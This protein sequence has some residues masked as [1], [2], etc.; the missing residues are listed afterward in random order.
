MG[1]GSPGS[2]RTKLFALAIAAATLA[3]PSFARAQEPQPWSNSDDIGARVV[4]AFPTDPGGGRDFP[5]R[6]RGA[7][8]GGWSSNING[9]CYGGGGCNGNGPYAQS[10]IGLNMGGAEGIVAADI[11]GLEGLEGFLS[12]VS[13]ATGFSG[14]SGYF[15]SSNPDQLGSPAY[16]WGDDALG[17]RYRRAFPSGGMAWGV[18]GGAMLLG[19]S[20]A[21]SGGFAGPNTSATGYFA[22]GLFSWR[23]AHG[24]LLSANAGFY[25]DN[26]WQIWKAAASAQ[27]PPV[28]RD[29]SGEERIALGHT[30][31]TQPTTTHTHN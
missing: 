29:I 25:L 22:R 28:T 30:T 9:A 12:A 10:G 13:Y 21:G 27:T 18:E 8:T 14:A 26:S 11:P 1:L 2:C 19:G 5:Y 23:E 15:T 31:N 3:G 4:S 17:V 6:I 20:S 24:L 16:Q 7:L